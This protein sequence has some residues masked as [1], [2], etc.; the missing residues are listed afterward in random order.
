MAWQR[1]S[2]PVAATTGPGS[3]VSSEP[4]TSATLGYSRGERIGILYL[5]SESVITAALVTSE[6]VPQVVG[7]ATSGGMDFGT[8][9]DPSMSRM[10]TSGL[11]ITAPAALAVSI[12]DPPPTPSRQSHSSAL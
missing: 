1:A 9:P 12:A 6:P 8:C 2:I 5:C 10:L 4:S 11:F 7:M 3:V